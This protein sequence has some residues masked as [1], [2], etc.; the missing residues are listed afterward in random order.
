[1]VTCNSNTE[2]L[3]NPSEC[4][5]PHAEKSNQSIKSLQ[6]IESKS[7]CGK[8]ENKKIEIKEESKLL[9]NNNNNNN[10]KFEGGGKKPA[11]LFDMFGDMNIAELNFDEL[12]P[13][14]ASVDSL[15]FDTFPQQINNI[16]SHSSS[17]C[18][19]IK[20]EEFSTSSL[21]CNSNIPLQDI[22]LNNKKLNTCNNDPLLS[23]FD[24]DKESHL[25]T[26]DVD[27][28]VDMPLLT[29]G[30]SPV[31]THYNDNNKLC[32]SASSESSPNDFS[33]QNDLFSASA[34]Q[35]LQ[36]QQQQQQHVSQQHPNPHLRQV[37]HHDVSTNYF[38][39]AMLNESMLAT[40]LQNQVAAGY[41]QNPAIMSH[42]HG[43][44]VQASQGTYYTHPALASTQHGFSYDSLGMYQARVTTECS[45]KKGSNAKR[46][47][48]TQ[49]S[50]F[51]HVC[52]RSGDQVR[53]APCAN[54]TSGLCRKAVCE[55]C[56]E[57]HGFAHEWTTAS[58]N[59]NI[60]GEMNNRIR[61]TLPEHAWTCFHCRSQCP[62]T[63]QCK[64]YAR[65]NKRRHNQL[66]Q[67]KAE[68]ERAAAERTTAPSRGSILKGNRKVTTTARG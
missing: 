60:I 58:Y 57:K 2:K 52:V 56:F 29:L 47:K 65:T 34:L 23:N 8:E 33:N 4:L 28:E 12:D 45:G 66:K 48:L 10:E 53:L 1:M 64:I 67:K 40:M 59:Y 26:D 38:Q 55:K 35:T 5:V 61:D 30:R 54:V 50:K 16:S 17:S 24:N 44:P 20:T 39:Q 62:P 51:C 18:D 6:P 19:K 15:L 31:D 68:K 63:A 36:A 37:S 22:Q 25:L 43:H 14:C 9:N 49:P 7:N 32:D 3:A 13:N 41:N 42:F 11:I 27:V 21:S 46:Y